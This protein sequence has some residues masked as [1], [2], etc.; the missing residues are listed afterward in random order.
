VQVKV[1]LELPG[2]T[3]I[4]LKVVPEEAPEAVGLVVNA[5]SVVL[6]AVVQV[7]V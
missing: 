2:A 5:S 4:S 6:E 3:R 1:A 7:K